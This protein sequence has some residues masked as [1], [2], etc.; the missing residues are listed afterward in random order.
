MPEVGGEASEPIRES[1]VHPHENHGGENEPET[2]LAELV[3]KDQPQSSLASHGRDCRLDGMA[4]HRA[5]FAAGLAAACAWLLAASGERA[6][7]SGGPA[8]IASHPVRLDAQKKLLSWVPADGPYARVA[9]LAWKTLETKFPIQDNGLETWLASSRFDP[10][11]HEGI[12]WPHNPAGLYA[13]LADSAALWYAFSGDHAAI[14]LVQ[15]AL[16][17]QLAHGTTPANWVWARVPYASAGA[18]DTDY[19]GADD[20]WCNHCGRGDGVG[21]VEP[22]KIGELGFAYLKFFEITGADRYRDAAIAC[23]DAL[24]EHVRAGDWRRSPW[25]FRVHASTGVAREEYSSN[26]VGALSLFDELMRL[27]MG[28]VHA[29]ARARTMA[30][31]WLM[32]VPM[33]NDAWSGYFEDI[34]IQ[35]DP[36]ANP[37]QY[38]AL[39]TAAWL[40]AHRE[41]DPAWR[42]HVAHL[43]AWSVQRFGGDTDRERGTQWGATVLSEQAADMAKMGSHTARFGATVALWFEATGD[44]AARE[45]A[46]RSLN[47]ATYT[48]DTNGVVAVGE[49]N[50]E[51]W[52]FSDGY[53]D[54][55]RHFL[56]AM[57]AV[58]EWAPARE[59]H[60][61]RS[62]STVTRISYTPNRV[63]FTTFDAEATE[64]LRL[65][66]EPA[67]VRVAGEPILRSEDTA[68]QGYTLAALPSGG[69]VM[70]LHHRR[71]G[72]VVLSWDSSAP[73]R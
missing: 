26:V 56:V 6:A 30:E 55:V 14:A 46:A 71:R 12:N 58:P 72:E 52:W 15:K 62:T 48:C 65:V 60:V 38:S 5:P 49:D 42:D 64:T 28:D 36:A 9:G 34:E 45:T 19:G 32:R 13:M 47:W 8:V 73:R 61:V 40:L 37:N 1:D 57:G 27:S 54:Y 4:L 39:R 10:D 51:G 43:L 3:R 59:N 25:P 29:Y 41:A 69:V 7:G 68:D 70:R 22:D 53:G 31:A 66:A 2:A 18:G 50:N 67:E 24:A 33:K 20:E 16:D 21:V 44:D 17:Y 23:A 11:T 63:A 35:D